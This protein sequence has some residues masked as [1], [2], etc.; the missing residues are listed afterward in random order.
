VVR[1]PQ[2]STIA[3]DVEITT[4]DGAVHLMSQTAARGS[5]VNPMSDRDL[6]QKL[7]TAA[8][9]LDH[10]VVPLIDAVWALEDSADVSRLA[11]LAVP[12]DRK[13]RR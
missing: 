2:F 4:S 3:A 13:D 1:D 7:K 9:S 11:L 5:D 12:K 6:V 8:A 10:D